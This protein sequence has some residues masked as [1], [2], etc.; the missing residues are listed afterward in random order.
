LIIWGKK[1]LSWQTFL[2]IIYQCII[3]LELFHPYKYTNCVFPVLAIMGL[4]SFLN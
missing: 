4:Q 1:T 2:S 3:N